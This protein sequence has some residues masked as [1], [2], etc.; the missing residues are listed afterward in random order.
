MEFTLLYQ[1]PLKANGQPDHKQEIRKEFHAQLKK[2]WTQPPLDG[3][4]RYLEEIPAKG[5]ISV[6][7]KFDD[8]SF[9][10]L[11]TEELQMVAEIHVTLL[12][13][14]APGS[15]VTQGG[16]IDNRIKTLLDS[17]RMPQNKSELP[18]DTLPSEEENPFFCLLEDDNLITKL[19]IDTDRLLTPESKS[20][21]VCLLLKITIKAIGMTWGNM[22]LG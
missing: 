15:I 16:D 12:R 22:G 1:G 17:L 21:D 7:K 8:F 9:A 11:V 10:P 4:R 13:P 18:K 3:Y 14:E 20:S 2:L 5:E 6:I 19:E